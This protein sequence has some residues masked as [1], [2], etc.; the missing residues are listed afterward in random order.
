MISNQWS[1]AMFRISL[2][3]LELLAKYRLDRYRDAPSGENIFIRKP[4]PRLPISGLLPCFASI[5][6][7]FRGVR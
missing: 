2:T 5:S 4:D 7:H 3:V 6:N 1:F